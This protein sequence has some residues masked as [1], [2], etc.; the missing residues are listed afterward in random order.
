MSVTAEWKGAVPTSRVEDEPCALV[1]VSESGMVVGGLGGS[2]SGPVEQ[3]S[4]QAGV[5]VPSGLSCPVLLGEG[6][7]GKGRRVGLR[8]AGGP[9]FT[10]LPPRARE[11]RRQPRRTE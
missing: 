9:K 3:A 8:E 10:S 5:V 4:K 6:W 1:R 11:L 7:R 2:G